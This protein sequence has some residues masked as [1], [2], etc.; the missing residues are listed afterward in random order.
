MLRAIQ[1][2]APLRQKY[3]YSLGLVSLAMV[4]GHDTPHKH[5]VQVGEVS[6]LNL[7]VELSTKFREIEN[8]CC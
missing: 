4:P 8:P 3:E 5:Y 1:T 2:T 6:L 7:L